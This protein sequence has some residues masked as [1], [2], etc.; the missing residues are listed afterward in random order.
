M[1]MRGLKPGADAGVAAE[2]HEQWGQMNMTRVAPLLPTCCVCSFAAHNGQPKLLTLLH[3][4]LPNCYNS[5][6]RM[7]V[8]RSQLR[9]LQR[10]RLQRV[11]VG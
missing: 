5:A 10:H 1:S 9:L 8:G 6:L 7:R 11:G 3:P 4:Y 2:D